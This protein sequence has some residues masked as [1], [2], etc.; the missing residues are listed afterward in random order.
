MAIYAIGIEYSGSGYSGWQRQKHSRSIQEQLENALGYVADHAVKLVCAGRTDTGVHAVEQVAHFETHAIRNSRS[1][2]LGANC[3]IARDIRIKWAV[4]VDN[5][6][7]ARFSAIARSYRYIILNS[8]VASALFHGKVNWQH[9]PLDHV[10]MDR[11]AQNLL[12]EHD[13]SAFRAAGCQS[14]SC[15]RNIHQISVTRQGD[16]VFLDIKA[17][18]FLYHMVRNIAGS[19]IEVGKGAKS[20]QWFTQVFEAKNRMQAAMTAPAEGLYMVRV[21]YPTQFKLPSQAKKPILF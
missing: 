17:N 20:Q 9:T 18:A 13:F 6:F 8:V 5:G 1:W 3:Q 11:A 7:H 16:M 4:Q 19:L 12:G 10:I 2:V 15:N 14:R 21:Y